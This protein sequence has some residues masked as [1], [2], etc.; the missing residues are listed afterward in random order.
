M[1][2]CVRVHV[3]ACASVCL[4]VHASVSGEAQLVGFLNGGCLLHLEAPCVCVI[5][6]VSAVSECEWCVCINVLW[7]QPVGGLHYI[8]AFNYM[9][10]PIS[11]IYLVSFSRSL[12]MHM[13]KHTY[14]CVPE[15]V[16]V[17]VW[18]LPLQDLLLFTTMAQSKRMTYQS[19][20]LSLYCLRIIWK[21]FRHWRLLST[22]CS[23]SF[24]DPH[25][26]SHPPC[27]LP[28][29]IFPL[30]ICFLCVSPHCLVGGKK[31]N[32]E[33]QWICLHKL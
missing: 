14:V 1:G 12:R 23:E 24:R 31:G 11:S 8:L 5:V 15:C 18:L 22:G 19:C 16:W 29:T 9:Q 13:N 6:S 7:K 30:F 27:H 33:R 21:C 3:R 20:F 10:F 26:T 17:Y 4:S 2:L 32:P 25:S 28:I